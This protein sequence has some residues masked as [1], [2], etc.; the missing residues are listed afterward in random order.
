MENT[1]TMEQKLDIETEGGNLNYKIFHITIIC[2]PFKPSNSRVPQGEE[3]KIT[4]KYLNF[5]T[6]FKCEDSSYF[7]A[8]LI[9]KLI[10]LYL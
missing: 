10:N 1:N 3:M 4:Y 8:W 7:T 5:R 6:I 9:N 2:T